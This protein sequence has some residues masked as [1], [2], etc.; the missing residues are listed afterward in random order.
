MRKA[1]LNVVSIVDFQY[2][3]IALAVVTG[4]QPANDAASCRCSVFE[5]LKF[6][7]NQFDNRVYTDCVG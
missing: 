7:M 2:Y 3:C 5:K 6:E 1:T 4:G